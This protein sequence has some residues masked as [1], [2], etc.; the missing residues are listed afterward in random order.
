MQGAS[1]MLSFMAFPEYV[2]QA[3]LNEFNK[4]NG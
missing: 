4:N 2:R 3:Y 1:R